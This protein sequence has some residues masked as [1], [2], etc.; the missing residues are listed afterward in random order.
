MNKIMDFFFLV[1]DSNFTVNAN[2]S[3]CSL[4]RVLHSPV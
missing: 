4:D 2:I 1:I 3:F